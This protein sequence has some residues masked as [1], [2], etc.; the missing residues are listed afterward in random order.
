MMCREEVVAGGW[1]RVL[2][3]HAGPWRAR[4]GSAGSTDEHLDVCISGSSLSDY[5]YQ[6]GTGGPDPLSGTVVR[7]VGQEAVAMGADRL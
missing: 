6:P 3:L 7:Q 1:F 2:C 5:L 4:D